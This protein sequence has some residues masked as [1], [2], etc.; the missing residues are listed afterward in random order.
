LSAI[1]IIREIIYIVLLV[2]S[3]LIV[4]RAVLSWFPA[5][6]GGR[7]F[8]VKRVV[9][10]LTEPYLRLFRRI[11]PTARFGQVGFDLSTFA[12]LIVIFIAIQLLFRI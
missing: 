4:A 6:P 10:I 5:R 7:L 12:G 8:L 11:V 9:H 1:I 3:W 2:Y